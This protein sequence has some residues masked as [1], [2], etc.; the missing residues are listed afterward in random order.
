MGFLL[1]HPGGGATMLGFVGIP[2]R[3]YEYGFRVRMFAGK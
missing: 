3:R 2:L 1:G